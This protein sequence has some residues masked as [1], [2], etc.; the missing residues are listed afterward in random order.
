MR[1]RYIQITL[2]L[3]SSFGAMAHNAHAVLVDPAVDIPIQLLSFGPL[4]AEVFLPLTN[5]DGSSTMAGAPSATGDGYG[6]VNS[7]IAVTLSSQGQNPGQPSTGVAHFGLPSGLGSVAG[8]ARTGDTVNVVSFFDVYFDIVITDAD[9]TAGFNPT[10]GQSIQQFNV[11]AMH[12]SAS[13]T[14]VADTAKPNL[15][16]LPMAGATYNVGQLQIILGVPDINGNGE[17]DLLKLAMT[18]FGIGNVTSSTQ[19]NDAVIDTFSAFLLGE[20]SVQ[21]Q[22]SDPPFTFQL[23]GPTTA[24]Q[25]LVYDATP[26]PEPSTLAL[27]GLGL[28]A[29]GAARRRTGA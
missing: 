22:S 5:A 29:F 27:L 19:G 28:A 26:V 2:A 20:G 8:D 15:G 14:C 17:S 18:S 7:N 9:A 10:I 1:T 3:V 6:W 21:D 4:Q 24:S 25:D 16:C 12:F 11:G 13:G 23:T